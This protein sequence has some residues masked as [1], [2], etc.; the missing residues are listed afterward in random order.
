MAEGQVISVAEKPGEGALTIVTVQL[1]AASDDSQGWELLLAPRSALADIG[2]EVEVGDRL[3]ARIFPSEE[4]PAKVH[5]VLNLTRR[6]MV[7][8]RSLFQIPLWDGSGAWQGGQCL[9]LQ[10]TVGQSRDVQ[11]DQRY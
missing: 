11:P 4:G 3:K 5:K 10:T 9:E 1:V 6:K 2:F 7:R 8:L